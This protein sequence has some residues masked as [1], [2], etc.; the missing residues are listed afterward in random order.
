MAR[1][2]HRD[3]RNR[4]PE[5][6]GQMLEQV[7]KRLGVEEKFSANSVLKNWETIV[8]A[9]INANSKPHKVENEKLIVHVSNSTWLME[10]SRFYK[11]KILQEIRSKANTTTI[12]DIVFKIGPVR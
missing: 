2:S 11:Q 12:K 3:K 5:P 9:E 7:L 10:L 4:G 6:I 1:L 8:G